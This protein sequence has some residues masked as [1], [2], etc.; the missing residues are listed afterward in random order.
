MYMN[1]GLESEKIEF[2]KSTSE[3]IKDVESKQINVELTE[4]ETL[5][6]NLIKN[7]KNI[8]TK[9]L[10]KLA[11]LSERY[12]NKIIKSLKD[13]NYI[14]RVGSNKTGYWKVL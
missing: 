5:I 2:K 8:K 10:V 9:E 12:V 11:K 4:A 1:L 7:D 6:L 3:L 14:E 13:K